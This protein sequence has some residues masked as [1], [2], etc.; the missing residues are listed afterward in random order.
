ML[1]QAG[2]TVTLANYILIFAKTQLEIWARFVKN[3]KIF[4]EIKNRQPGKSAI[5]PG[6]EREVFEIFARPCK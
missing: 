2:K 6:L 5:L 4:H 3:R 1:L